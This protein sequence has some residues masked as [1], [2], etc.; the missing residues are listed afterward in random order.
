[1]RFPVAPAPEPHVS[2]PAAALAPFPISCTRGGPWAVWKCL[3]PLTPPFPLS[4]LFSAL[5]SNPC[6]SFEALLI[7]APS[8]TPPHGPTAH[9]PSWERLWPF[10]NTSV[11]S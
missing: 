8:T 6:P 11:R 5:L 9:G 2:S 1:M 4:G 10:T 7:A 3:G